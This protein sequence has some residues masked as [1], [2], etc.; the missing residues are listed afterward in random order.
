MPH[1]SIGSNGVG[2]L[3]VGA[4]VDIDDEVL[5]APSNRR[6]FDD[7]IAFEWAAHGLAAFTD[8]DGR[9]RTIEVYFQDIYE[10]MNGFV[11][12]AGTTDRGVGPA[13]TPDAVEAAYGAAPERRGNKGQFLVYPGMLFTF[14]GGSLVQIS[15]NPEIAPRKREPLPPPLPQTDVGRRALAL[16]AELEQRVAALNRD[17]IE[18]EFTPA[19]A[20]WVENVEARFGHR[21]PPSYRE[22]VLRR[23]TLRVEVAGA[24]ALWMIPIEDLGGPE[25][26]GPVD[27]GDEVVD[28]AV[29]RA[30]FFAYQSDDAVEDFFA[31]D[32]A[33]ASPDGEMPVS[34]YRHDERFE[35][36]GGDSFADYLEGEIERLF[37]YYV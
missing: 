11:P 6:V 37:K 33:S 20:A 9:V 1:P 4:V 27:E 31:F 26:T 19:E 23:G 5:G 15:L 18:L 14:D 35:G 36:G 24:I 16:V 10:Q 22:L 25:P 17:D 30:I 8:L 34:A 28:D 21:L 7:F 13:A 2:L 12:F 29:A 3:T 32:P